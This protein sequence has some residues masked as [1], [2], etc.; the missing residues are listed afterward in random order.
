MASR[1][2]IR[3]RYKLGQVLGRGGMGVVYQAYDTLMKRDVA[4]KTLLD[5]DNQTSLGLFYKEWAV[6]AGMVHPN[7]VEIF[8]IG[9]F[10][11]DGQKKPFFVMPL[12]RGVSL[13]K[14]I[15]EGSPRLTVP[16]VVNILVQAARG[17]QA[18]HDMGLVHRDVKPSNI[19][20]LEDDS[21]KIIDFGIARA[22]SDSK[23]SLKGTLAYISPEQIQMKPP[24]ALS[25]QYALGIV[26]YEALTRRLPFQGGSD[27]DVIEA[28][29]HRSPPPVSELNGNVS[30]I[31]SQVVH[32]A[33][34][35]QPWH[36]FASLREFS[37][38]LQKAI[39][40]ERLEQFEES[41]L[42][43]R[44][45]K[46]V[47]R[48]EAG[49]YEFALELLT[50]IEGEGH[51]DQEIQLVRSQVDQAVRTTRIRTLLD[52][53]RRYF[54]AEEYSLALRKI[55]EA[56]EIAP[57]DTDALALKN[58]VEK[59]RRSKQIDEWLRIARQHLENQ[60]FDQAQTA[61]DN[62]LKLKADD[63]GGLQFANE[64]RRRQEQVERDRAEKTGLYNAAMKLWERGEVTSALTKLESLAS[65]EREQPDPDK[66][67]GSTYQSFYNQVR[68]ESDLQKK[69]YDEARRLLSSENFAQALAICKQSLAKYPNHALFQALFYD[70]EERRRQKLSSVIAETDRKVEQEPD[71][72]R[73]VALLD[74]VIKDYP[75]EPH[76]E[77]ALRLVRD[78]RDLVNSIVDKA[79]YLE[80]QEQFGEA[81]DQ[82]QILK[83]IHEAY[84]GLNF[85]IERLSKR[86][87]QAAREAAQSRWVEKIDR[88]LA[89]GDYDQAVNIARDALA[90]FPGD[91]E[92]SELER[93][94]RRDRERGEQAQHLVTRARDL[95][96]DGETTDAISVLREAFQLDPKSAVIRAVL[97][98]SLLQWARDTMNE[99]AEAPAP[100][101][102]EVLEL[103]PDNASAK[104][105]LTQLADRK[106]GDFIAWTLAQSRRLQAEGDLEGAMV[107]A[108]HGL[109]IF[110]NDTR[111]QQLRVSLE[112]N[113]TESVILSASVVFPP[114]K[115]STQ[116]P[117]V[118]P[119]PSSPRTPAPVPAPRA[120]S[121]PPREWWQDREN[122]KWMLIGAGILVVLLIAWIV[123]A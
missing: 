14:L 100:V 46:A 35:K 87:D 103:E 105:L 110:P 45:Q 90:E 30:F 29:L 65:L 106:R 56:L 24:S 9:E 91:S 88:C 57:E 2:Q 5:I 86:R 92:L 25:D 26:I 123:L 13:D 44:L 15:R 80:E 34:A 113:L 121:A 85:E 75:G 118:T 33:M 59:E 47:E 41:R 104:S 84:P 54:E 83:S 77:Q 109:E 108:K 40:G 42:K 28:I 97:V 101:L 36:R 117:G 32:K 119:Q 38:A 68:S 120:T 112:R 3:D 19:F 17:L 43:P 64:L 96:D 39:R 7:V 62:V 50:E 116:V 18:A 107:V 95:S 98:N 115:T 31:T 79:R 70:V 27:Q 71:L 69:R 23:T 94:A 61:L 6:L 73:R 21:V 67:R 12:L 66:A 4:L 49:D 58:A 55:Q 81:V 82:W 102:R 78:K 16:R 11:D 72:D 37:E 74:A 52:N 10:E 60:A 22:M 93:L 111:F 20:V 114:R 1:S 51:L 8:D 122:Q 53:A 48:Y 99:D 89:S 76:F 63:A